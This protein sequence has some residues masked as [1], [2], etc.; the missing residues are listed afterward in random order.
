MDN[1]KE[2]Y[3][4][5]L[6]D[7][8]DNEYFYIGKGKG[9]RYLSHLGEIKNMDFNYAK[10]NKIKEIQNAGYKVKIEILFPNLDEETAFEL[11]KI[12]IYKLGRKILSEGVLT[13]MNP[14][15]NWKRK[16]SLLYSSEFKGEFDLKKLNSFAQE[17]FLSIP[18]KSQFNYLNTIDGKQIVYHYDRKG[19]IYIIK[20]LNC[21][22]LDGFKEQKIELIKA[23]NNNE[24][25]IYLGPIYSKYFCNN[26]YIS[27][28]LPL[29][30]FDI[31]DEQFNKDFDELYEK[32]DNFKIEFNLNGV[33][34]M[35]V[36]RKK[37]TISLQSFYISGN[38]K[39]FR[40]TINNKVNGISYDWYEN[41]NLKLK[42]VYKGG[43]SKYIRTTYFENGNKRI[44]TSNFD[45]EET[46]NSWFENGKKEVE[47][48][49]DI[50]YVY[51]NEIGVKI[52]SNHD[53]NKIKNEQDQLTFNF[54]VELTEEMKKE[55]EQSDLDWHLYQSRFD[56]TKDNK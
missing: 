3:V 15:G 37:E 35:S 46:Y 44:E 4:Y 11:E 53:K 56:N 43:Y 14:G 39:S 49:K 55:K 42:I 5:A 41:G 24:L 33:L 20:S 54:P 6:I 32:K 31:V 38:K 47:L 8:R 2:Y 19:N 27:D 18:Q 30:E 16:D 51:Y 52:T 40:Q 10:H 26:I 13:N 17:K 21:F 28:K 7:P 50:G 23:L 25:P 36:E 34:R 1:K 9:K 48:I 45:D 12:L 22:L 29:A